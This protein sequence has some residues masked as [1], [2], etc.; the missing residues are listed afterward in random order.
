MDADEPRD[1][2]LGPDDLVV[3]RPVGTVSAIDP[4]VTATTE[5]AARVLFGMV[6]ILSRSVVELLAPAPRPDAAASTARVFPAMDLALA[7][8][9]QAAA[10][11]GRVAGAAARLASP[12]AVVITDPPIVPASLRP[13]TYLRSAVASW[14]VQR[15]ALEGEAQRA[16][17]RTVP[18]A[19]D[20]LLAPID[21]T[22]LVVD[23]VQLADVVMA[24]LADLDLTDVVT[25]QVD[26][27][28]VI[29][30]A[31]DEL[32]L[33]EIVVTRVDVLGLAEYVVNGID[34]PAIIRGST[35][36]VASEGVRTLRM[37]SVDADATVARLVDRVLMWRRG[38]VTDAP[39]DPESLQPPQETS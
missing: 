38:R 21:L 1:G 24:A 30:S 27:R 31:L 12:V 16:W 6:S 28:T 39:G 7:L 34:L 19:A 14:Q 4:G 20:T 25:S 26:L 8:G 36:S 17:R 29:Q 22:K 2:P 33:T 3:G 32:D 5:A 11:A 9:W 13:G 37:Q 10:S 18:V 15:P 35:G 23:Q